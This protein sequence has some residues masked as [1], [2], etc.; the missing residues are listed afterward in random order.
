M[1]TAPTTN[2][3]DIFHWPILKVVYRTDA[4]IT[5]QV[6]VLARIDPRRLSAAGGEPTRLAIRYPCALIAGR[7]GESARRFL[8]HLRGPEATAIFRR[9]G[10]T[11]P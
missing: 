8:A 1:S 9:F 10:F 7:G 11:T 5:A 3:G 4:A 6:R 2:P